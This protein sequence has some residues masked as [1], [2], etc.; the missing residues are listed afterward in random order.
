LER[1]AAEKK[2]ASCSEVRASRENLARICSNGQVRLSDQR[3]CVGGGFSYEVGTEH[4]DVLVARNEVQTDF[5]VTNIYRREGG[6]WRMVHHHTDLN[7]R[8][9]EI[10]S[11][12]ETSQQ[13]VSGV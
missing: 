3:I 4:V 11:K 12:L 8:M 5:R 13:N 1:A 7:L 9:L 2:A 10:L 6:E